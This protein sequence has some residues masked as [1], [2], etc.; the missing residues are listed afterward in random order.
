MTA[1]TKSSSE[2]ERDARPIVVLDPRLRP[3]ISAHEAFRVLGIDR[4]TGYKAIREGTFPVPVLR[5][6]RIIRVPTFAL[7]QVLQVKVG[8][9]PERQG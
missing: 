5:I 4:A 2:G 3:T 7:L 6:G 9:H 8:S 1:I